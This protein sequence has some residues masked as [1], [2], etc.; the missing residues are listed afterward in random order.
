MIAP[1]EATQILGA[2]AAYDQRTVGAFEANAW[3]AS[4]NHEYP[5]MMLADA[6]EA[7]IEWHA[8]STEGR[9]RVSN[10]I[11]G[12]K[13]VARRRIAAEAAQRHAPGCYRIVDEFG[14]AAADQVRAL[15]SG[16]RPADGPG[17]RE[18]RR[19]LEEIAAKRSIPEVDENESPSDRIYRSALIRARAD[20]RERRRGSRVGD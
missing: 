4:I 7:V 1:S 15:E 11:S 8:T 9:M 20:K 14:Q 13:V 19:V 3:A 12:A 2:I 17:L 5:N 16:E 6:I 18:L 10:V